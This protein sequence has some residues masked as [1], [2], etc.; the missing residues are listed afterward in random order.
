[1]NQFRT[2]GILIFVL[3]FVAASIDRLEAQGKVPSNLQKVGRPDDLSAEQIRSVVQSQ[4]QGQIEK[5][6]VLMTKWVYE[7]DRASLT[8]PPDLAHI[9]VEVTLKS[10][11]EGSREKFRALVLYARDPGTSGPWFFREVKQSSRSEFAGG[12]AVS[13]E[14]LLQQTL[15]AIRLDVRKWFSPVSTVY[16]VRKV[17]IL[18]DSKFERLDDN[19]TRWLAVLVFDQ[20]AGY[21]N[22]R[23]IERIVKVSRKPDQNGKYF[24]PGPEKVSEK[25][26]SEIELSSSDIR[27]LPNLADTPFDKL[28]MDTPLSSSATPATKKPTK[29]NDR[30]ARPV[31]K[32]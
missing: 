23:T 11:A 8:Q 31:R 32:R 14:Q 12:K 10:S 30:Q 15:E 26:I 24:S 9:Q 2:L 25:I 22:V 7:R 21:K 6:E 1:M 18:E 20:K 13:N 27:N 4:I 16:R 3:L 28:F 19:E 5:F 29:S 17:A